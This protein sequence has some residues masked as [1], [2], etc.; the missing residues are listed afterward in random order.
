MREENCPS[1]NRALHLQERIFWGEPAHPDE[2]TINPRSHEEI[3]PVSYI[4]W[5]F[6]VH[7]IC[8]QQTTSLG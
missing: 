2:A 7:I 3:R 1:R 6:D 5:G 4:K 8:H